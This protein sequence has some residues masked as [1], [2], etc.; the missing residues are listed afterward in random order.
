MFGKGLIK[1][2]LKPWHSKPVNWSKNQMTD[3]KLTRVVSKG[4]N[5]TPAKVAACEKLLRLPLRGG[6]PSCE[7]LW[8]FH[9][10]Q[11]STASEK[12]RISV[13][14]LFPLIFFWILDGKLWSK[15][16]IK[17]HWRLSG[18]R[19]TPHQE[20]QQNHHASEASL[21]YTVKLPPQEQRRNKPK[22]EG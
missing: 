13:L 21:G 20:A 7:L 9:E 6:K 19:S 2:I 15:C 3:M 10:K 18:T 17:T 1:I 8:C 12:Q 14:N 4:K 16:W 11:K 22:K 5:K